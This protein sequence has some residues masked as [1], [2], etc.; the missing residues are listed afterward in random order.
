VWDI[1]GQGYTGLTDGGGI[2][3]TGYLPPLSVLIRQERKMGMN[4]DTY[5][6]LKLNDLAISGIILA[7]IIVA[8]LVIGIVRYFKD[9]R[10]NGL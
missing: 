1:H 3:L 4:W 2:P 8:G 6:A 7:A 5:W 10:G 9:T